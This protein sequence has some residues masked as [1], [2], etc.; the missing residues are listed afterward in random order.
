MFRKGFTLIELLVVITILAVLAGAA[1][2]YVQSYV[3]EAKIA[4]AK[5]DLEE[6]ARALAVYETREGD[7]VKADVGDLTGRYLNKAPIDPWGKSYSVASNSGTAFSSGPDRDPLTAA[8]NIIVPYQPPLALV[9]VK[10]VDKNQTGAVDN[11][12]ASDQVQLSFSRRL[13]HTSADF[14]GAGKLNGF[15]LLSNSTMETAFSNATATLLATKTLVL[16]V[17][18]SNAFT[19]GSDTIQIKSP[20]NLI[21]SANS[22]ALASQAVR[23]L[24][25]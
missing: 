2:P 25:Q 21:D 20:T 17:A 12:N 4:K 16:D 15:F 1:L 11:Q 24:P 14:V 7:Y 18:V 3:E 6:I 23:I 22:K 19:P 8:D 5:T 13:N 9:Q 10:W